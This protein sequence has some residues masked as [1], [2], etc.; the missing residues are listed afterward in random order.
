MPYIL[1]AD[2]LA[3][4][5]N[6]Y[7]SLRTPLDPRSAKMTERTRTYALRIA[8]LYALLDHT[9]YD[10]DVRHL[11]VGIAVAKYARASV[12]ALFGAAWSKDQQKVIKALDTAGRMTRTDISSKVLG[13]HKSS[14]ELDELRDTLKERGAIT[15]EDEG[16]GGAQTEVWIRS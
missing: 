11:E 4:W 14:S 7:S 15:V 2:A 16:V 6:E 12:A 9:T 3:L 13:R 8:L 5:E 10:I 1:T